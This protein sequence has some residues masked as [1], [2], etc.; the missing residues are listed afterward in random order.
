MIA[1]NSIAA[2]GVQ[3]RVTLEKFN[4]K[5]PTRLNN[6]FRRVALLGPKQPVEILVVDDV[7]ETREVTVT[8]PVPGK[9]WYT[10]RFIHWFKDKRGNKCL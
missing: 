10:A 9:Y 3:V 4:G 8:S 5:A 2:P 6:A 7:T 1:P